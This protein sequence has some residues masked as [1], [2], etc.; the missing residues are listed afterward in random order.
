MQSRNLAEIV[1]G[2]IVLLVAAAFVVFAVGQ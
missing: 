2:G 1:T